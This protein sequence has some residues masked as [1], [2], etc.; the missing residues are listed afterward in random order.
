MSKN[1]IG[2]ND[3]CP[4]GS[5]KKYKN[6]CIASEEGAGTDLF[7]R[8]SQAIASIKLKLDQEYKAEIK[9]IRKSS[10]QNFLYYAVDGQLPVQHESLF[11]DWLWFDMADEEDNTLALD[12]LREH[13]NFMPDQLQESLMALISSYLSVYEPGDSGDGFM[14]VRDIFSG[15]R[16]QVILKEALEEDF[17]GKS[18]LLLGRLVSL[19]EGKVFSGM[20]L[21]IE[22]NDGQENYLVQH[23]H[24]LQGLSSEKGLTKL[25]KS[26]TD[27]LYGLFD[28]AYH[29]KHILINDI[30]VLNLSADNAA[31]LQDKLAAA[32]DLSFVHAIDGLHWYKAANE[33][34]YQRLALGDDYLL[35]CI[36]N[37]D[38]IDCWQPIL[39]DACPEIRA[40]QLVNSRFIRQAPPA[41]LV[42][43]WFTVMQDQETERWL[44]TPHNELDNKTP[45]EQLAEANGREKVLN[46]LDQFAS[47]LEEGN[48]GIELINYMRRR[49][50]ALSSEA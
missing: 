7:T 50:S 32:N 15:V 39:G 11:S 10:Q 3:P 24:Y 27:L 28:H 42:P 38:N 43:I 17:G 33:Q 22:N 16:E 44:Q 8:Y 47:R 37:L 18:Y 14:E 23:L 13:A 36:S 35:S 48:E 34:G 2:R 6:C 41:D 49:I 20:V 19:P 46:M 45:L 5:G 1:K 40:W 29:K 26:H 12:Y 9:R 4:C 25:L 21:A 31:L 30:R